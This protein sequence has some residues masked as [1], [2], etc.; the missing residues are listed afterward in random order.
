MEFFKETMSHNQ[1]LPIFIEDKEEKLGSDFVKMGSDFFK[2]EPV[3]ILAIQN[4]RQLL[5]FLCTRVAVLTELDIYF[6]A[7]IDINV[8]F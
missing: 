1:S 2:L 8:F 4:Q 5:N 6:C 3:S 7:S